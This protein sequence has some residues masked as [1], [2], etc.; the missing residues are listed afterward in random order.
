MYFMLK[1]SGIQF[2]ETLHSLQN[3]TEKKALSWRTDLGKIHS[4]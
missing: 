4:A 2:E 1:T 3:I